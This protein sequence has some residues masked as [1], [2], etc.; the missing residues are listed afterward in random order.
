MQTYEGQPEFELLNRANFN[1]EDD[2]EMPQI[3]YL[4]NTQLNELAPQ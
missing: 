4:S 2:S 3:T 1:V